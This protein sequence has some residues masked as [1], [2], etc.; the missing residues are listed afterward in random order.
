MWKWQFLLSQCVPLYKYMYMYMY[1]SDELTIISKLTSHMQANSMIFP[2]Q[3]TE[4]RVAKLSTHN[5]CIFNTPVTLA[6]SSIVTI[7][8]HL[9]SSIVH[10]STTRQSQAVASTRFGTFYSGILLVATIK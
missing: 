6:H 3:L 2:S 1:I 10:T 8:T 7:Q 9:K 4:G 5:S